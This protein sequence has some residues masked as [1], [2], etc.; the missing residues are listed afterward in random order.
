MSSNDDTTYKTVAQADAIP[1]GSYHSATVNGQRILVC[2]TPEGFFTIE[3]ECSH[4][5]G[6]LKGGDL[7]DCLITCPLHGAQFDVRDGAP[8][9]T[10]ASKPIATFP[11]RV[12]NG[13]V[14]VHVPEPE[15]A[16]GDFRLGPFAG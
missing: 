13:A 15:P 11:T 9:A 3:N 2:H 6:R 14:Q 5:M 1:V 7:K 4:A 16:T 8:K 10:P 12:V